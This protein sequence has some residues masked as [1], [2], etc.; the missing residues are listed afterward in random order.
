MIGVREPVRRS[1][2]SGADTVPDDLPAHA[3]ERD[4]ERLHLAAV[5]RPVGAAM[6][7][8][9]AFEEADRSR[10]HG[11]RRGY[12]PAR[13]SDCDIVGSAVVAATAQPHFSVVPVCVQVTFGSPGSPAG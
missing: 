3:A 6:I 9:S 2:A 8:V 7:V 10:R 11:A 12:P 5:F 1:A 4:P 13:S